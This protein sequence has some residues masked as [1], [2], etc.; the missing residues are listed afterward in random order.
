MREW[1]E[2]RN[3]LKKHEDELL[4]GCIVAAMLVLVWFL[5]MIFY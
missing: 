4:S 2:K 3:A 5:I 1:E